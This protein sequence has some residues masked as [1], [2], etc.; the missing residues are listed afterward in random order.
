M[1]I[2]GNWGGFKEIFVERMFGVK[3]NHMQ[4]C[5]ISTVNAPFIHL[6]FSLMRGD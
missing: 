4:R 3:K 5:H 2:W 1:A 6:A